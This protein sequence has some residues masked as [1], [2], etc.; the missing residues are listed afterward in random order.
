MCARDVLSPVCLAAACHLA[1][2]CS[3]PLYWLIAMLCIIIVFFPN[4]LLVF[5]STTNL[6][7]CTK[8]WPFSTHSSHLES[9][10]FCSTTPL[11]TA[12]SDTWATVPLASLA[13]I[14]RYLPSRHYTFSRSYVQF[15]LLLLP[16]DTFFYSLSKDAREKTLIDRLNTNNSSAHSSADKSSFKQQNWHWGGLYLDRMLRKNGTRI[17]SNSWCF[18]F[19]AL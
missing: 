7:I 15:L 16:E 5:S 13:P 4:S 14:C 19:I 12:T 2:L 3:S 9:L 17:I 18:L 8:I 6:H 1:A 10:V 11:N